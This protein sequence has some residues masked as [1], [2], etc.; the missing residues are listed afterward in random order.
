MDEEDSGC[1]DVDREY[2]A[3]VCGH[4]QNKFETVLQHED[5]SDEQLDDLQE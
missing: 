1:D 2:W 3:Q 4:L 5:F